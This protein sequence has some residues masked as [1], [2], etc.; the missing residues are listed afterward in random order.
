MIKFKYKE[1]ILAFIYMYVMSPIKLKIFTEFQMIFFYMVI[2]VFLF[3]N[4]S[5]IYKLFKN[6]SGKKKYLRVA[7]LFFMIAFLWAIGA[8]IL[9]GTFD[10]TY[11]S[12]RFLSAVKYIVRLLFLLVLTNKWLKKQELLT[13]SFMR[14][15][16][17]GMCWYI[18]FSIIMVIFPGFKQFWSSVIIDTELNNRLS[19]YDIYASRYGLSGFSGHL[20][21]FFCS[22]GI[23]FLLFFL[24][25][26]YYSSRSDRWMY[27]VEIIILLIGNFFYGRV[28][29]LASLLSI[30][31]AVIYLLVKRG[32][33][34]LLLGSLGIFAVLWII[35]NVLKNVNSAMLEWYNWVFELFIN[36]VNEGE[37]STRS[38]EILFERM[39]FTPS[40]N[41]F[42]WGDGFYTDFN[43]GKYYMSTDAG[44][45]RPMLFY[46]IFGEIIMYLVPIF[47]ALGI[48]KSRKNFLQEQK[49]AL[50]FMAVTLIIQMFFFEI[51]GEVFYVMIAF[52]TVIFVGMF[53][54]NGSKNMQSLG[55]KYEKR[56]AGC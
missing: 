9:H 21:T 55:E 37:I 49:E 23:V 40:L 53:N 38:T 2:L 34:K 6:I 28:G 5:A 52:L 11:L 7:G 18:V 27:F 14:L 12:V 35:V 16:I 8:P 32:K 26:K 33:I 25:S 44:L 43:T 17:K 24:L 1:F 46:G 48:Y 39:Y 54:L 22:V 4:T 20:Y 42:F 13:Y 19:I 56:D 31:L 45:M 41:T 29:A 50:G 15:F 10:F 36:A 51:K 3:L 47:L 30:G